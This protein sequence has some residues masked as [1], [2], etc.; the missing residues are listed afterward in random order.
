MKKEQQSSAALLS[1][2]TSGKEHLWIAGVDVPAGDDFVSQ[3]SSE[4]KIQP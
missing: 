1:V 3:S 4:V 2:I